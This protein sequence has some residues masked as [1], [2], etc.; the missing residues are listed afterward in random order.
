VF[1]AHDIKPKRLLIFYNIIQSW[2]RVEDKNMDI[3]SLEKK[4]KII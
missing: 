1:M 3:E 4:L 2:A